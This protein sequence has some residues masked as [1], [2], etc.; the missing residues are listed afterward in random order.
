M[1]RKH[2]LKSILTV[3]LA[4]VV[5]FNYLAVFAAVEMGNI[6][7]T[8][9]GTKYGNIFTSDEQLFSVN[10]TNNSS[11]EQIAVIK[12]NIYDENNNVIFSGANDNTVV[13]AGDTVHELV[14]TSI[15]RY[16]VFTAEF[17]VYSQ[18]SVSQKTIPFSVLNSSARGDGNKDFLINTHLSRYGNVEDN[19]N[20]ISAA[21]FG[22]IRD[23]L[24]WNS[25]ETEKGVL[26]I[27][28]NRNT[29][30]I[31]CYEKQLDD[32]LI[33][34]Y[35]NKA[36]GDVSENTTTPPY[37]DEEMDAFAKYCG[38][39]ASTYKGKIQYYEVWN[40]YHLK[41][42]ND[43]NYDGTV[44]AKMLKKAYQAIKNAD[45]DAIVV[46]GAVSGLSD[47]SLGANGRGGA[48]FLREMFSV[49]D[50]KNYFDVLSIHLYKQDTNTYDYSWYNTYLNRELSDILND[51]DVS[52][53]IWMTETGF[54]TGT[55]L[56]EKEQAVA[57]QKCYIQTKANGLCDK[58]FYYDYQ[59]DGSNKNTAEHNYGIIDAASGVSTPGRA[60]IALPALA[61][62]NK[63]MA[64]A[65]Y[66]RKITKFGMT[67]LE[68]SKPDGSKVAAMWSD[69]N[70]QRTLKLDL[71]TDSITI[72]DMYSNIKRV[73]GNTNGI[74]TVQV[75]TE[76]IFITGNFS[77]FSQ[78]NST[79][80]SGE[81]SPEISFAIPETNRFE[82]AIPKTSVNID[83][84]GK[85][86]F[87]DGVNIQYS[88]CDSTGSVVKEKSVSLNIEENT[89]TKYP[90]SAPNTDEGT[91]TIDIS[92]TVGENTEFQSFN[93]TIVK[94]QSDDFCNI[95]L[96]DGTVSIVGKADNPEGKITYMIMDEYKRII[97]ANQTECDDG[98][99]SYSVG[100]MPSGTI[101]VIVNDGNIYIREFVENDMTAIVTSKDVTVTSLSQ[102]SAGDN[103][104]IELDIGDAC[105][106]LGKPIYI[107]I[108]KY[109]GN[110]LQSVIEK[111]VINASAGNFKLP[112]TLNSLE[113]TTK[114]SCFVWTEDLT[115]CIK[116]VDVE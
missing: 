32:L 97:Y 110:S 13:E 107:Y 82:G 17:Q 14:R 71:G 64:N 83:N 47:S 93:Y 79:D 43:A 31:L 103:M 84:S 15:A 92:V 7:F 23:T 89:I 81:A 11:E 73:Q 51:Y 19:L 100:N 74:Y 39:M 12:F 87:V 40:E 4:F 63:L 29:E 58:F 62:M 21:G 1:N 91:Y 98:I 76:P 116:Q 18:N 33:L 57:I 61:G 45:P 86:A 24:S 20:I 114:I 69:Y 105:P 75:G 65:S 2:F 8:V 25:V 42:F 53:P 68:F 104:N 6:T 36:Y 60:K 41:H 10:I 35:G 94:P 111:S 88:I 115:P 16:G 54:Y 52:K 78:A 55:N 44:Y 108:A 3:M 38:L 49:A 46:A 113:G 34:G 48:T 109:N 70:I 30:K 59:N 5:C 80:V 66:S 96:N 85:E 37:T 101:S 50:I 77:K 56:S 72:Y 22:G 99:Y 112:F 26:T 95:S 90:I 28:E 106:Y 102:I 67:I 9:S 27:P